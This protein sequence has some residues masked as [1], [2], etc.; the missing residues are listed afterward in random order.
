MH[1]SCEMPCTSHPASSLRH[2]LVP[3]MSGASDITWLQRCR[4]IGHYLVTEMPGHPTSPGSRDVGGG[5]VLSVSPRNS[6]MPIYQPIQMNIRF[7]ACSRCLSLNTGLPWLDLDT[8]CQFL[9]PHRTWSN[10]SGRWLFRWQ[11][12][13]EHCAWTLAR[14]FNY[15]GGQLFRKTCHFH[16][17]PALKA[18]GHVR[19]GL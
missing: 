9:I 6:V 10:S 15:S 16:W 7:L 17:W 19:G 4:G 1:A 5:W 3:E 14:T 2:Y 11:V 12:L 13:H 18:R 8:C